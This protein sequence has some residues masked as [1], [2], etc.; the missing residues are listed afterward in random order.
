MDF[1]EFLAKSSSL[2][3]TGGEAGTKKGEG[4]VFHLFPALR[5][6]IEKVI[7]ERGEEGQKHERIFLTKDV[8]QALTSACKRAGLPIWVITH[9]DIS[10]VRMQLV[11]R[12]INLCGDLHDG[13]PSQAPR[14]LATDKICLNHEG[15]DLHPQGASYHSDGASLIPHP[16]SQ[17]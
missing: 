1:V 11:V 6:L 14:P 2:V 3:V 7:R 5:Q 9:S 16:Y 12:S 8:R 17:S 10:S 15:I 4:R 13:L